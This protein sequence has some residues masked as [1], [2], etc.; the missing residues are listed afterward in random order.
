MTDL[1]RWAITN[2]RAVGQRRLL[3]DATVVVADGR[4]AD[5][6]T[7]APAPAGALDGH[8]LLLLPGL[9]DSH[10]D[11]L[12]KEI[13]PRRTASF[14][15][16]YALTSFEGKLR[17]AGVTTVFHGLPYQNRPG[18]GRTIEGARQVQSALAA[19]RN[20]PTAAVDHRLLYRFEAR[21]EVALDPL[22]EDLASSDQALDAGPVASDPTAVGG[23]APLISYEDHTPGQGQYRDPAQYAAALDPANLPPGV[24]AE[25]WVAKRMA[26][27][28]ELAPVRAK[29][30]DRLAP[31]AHRGEIRLLAHDLEHPSD[32]EWAAE[33]GATVAEFPVTAASARAARQ[34]DMTVVMGA[35][36][37]LRGG[38]HNANASARE[39][40]THGL[41]DVLASD[42]LPSA[43]LA[44]TFE[45]AA[46]GLCS[47]PRAVALVTAGPARM[48]GLTDR[49][50][51]E[52]GAVADLLLVDDSGRWPQ[53]VASWRADDAPAWRIL[54]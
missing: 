17:A 24:T 29:N 16:D 11:G 21:D 54:R 53:V 39:L 22:L 23:A 28:E 36:N 19:R 32:V 40:V 9:V 38:S 2:V 12:E 37:A 26:D 31:L 3:D 5:L 45:V 4:L 10:S 41:C 18:Q 49:G 33:A 1:D 13:A 7:G 42:Y 20:E 8:G 35:P 34:H 44:A 52:I 50:R 43:L 51:L 48:A 25:E 15:I 47:L 30:L 14:P 27:A 46:Q 6:T